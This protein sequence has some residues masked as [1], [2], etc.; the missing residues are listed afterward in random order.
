MFWQI[1]ANELNQIYPVAKLPDLAFAL[2]KQIMTSDEAQNFI[3]ASLND[4]SEPHF[5]D[6]AIE[7]D[8]FTFINN[9]ISYLDEE[10]EN[11]QKKLWGYIFLSWL[12]FYADYHQSRFKLLDHIFI[13][14]DRP[15][16]LTP[17][18]EYYQFLDDTIAIA[19]YRD[20][21]RQIILKKIAME[22]ELPFSEKP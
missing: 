10:N 13:V 14:L 16:F 8:Q 2:E 5:F 20:Q 7:N 6:L 1:K 15:N 21:Q 9:I 19:N 12:K 11:Y 18:E 22:L 3:I 4:Q 17:L